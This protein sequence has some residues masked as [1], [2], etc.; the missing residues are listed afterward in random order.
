MNIEIIEASVDDYG[1][2]MS[3]YYE[4]DLYHYEKMPLELKKPEEIAQQRTKESFQQLLGSENNILLMAV[5]EGQ[6]CGLIAANIRE[7][8][9]FIHSAKKVAYIDEVTVLS[10]YQGKGIAKYLINYLEAYFSAQGITEIELNVYQFNQSAIALYK[11]LGYEVKSQKMSKSI[12][13]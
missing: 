8:A 10:Q 7:R 13:V 5:S 6:V 9:S 11:G 4:S 1:V 3:L 2:L 12:I